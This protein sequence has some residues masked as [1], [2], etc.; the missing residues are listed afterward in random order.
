MNKH[1][2]AAVIGLLLVSMQVFPAQNKAEQ[3]RAEQLAMPLTRQLSAV[4]PDVH[5]K[6]DEGFDDS[7]A[8]QQSPIAIDTT[9]K[10]KFVAVNLRDIIF[11][12]RPL[13]L[14]A[15]NTGHS[16][17]LQPQEVPGSG[18]PSNFIVVDEKPYRFAQ[19][20]FHAPGEHKIDTL[21]Y[22]LEIHLVHTIADEKSP[23]AFNYAVIGIM[24]DIGVE[25]PEFEKILPK[26]PA[27]K[28]LTGNPLDSNF[29]LEKLLPADRRVMRYSGS[30]TTKP[31][32][33]GVTWLL[34]KQPITISKAQYEKIHAIMKHPNAREIQPLKVP[35]VSDLV[36]DK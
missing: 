17:E 6:T 12:Y 24:V 23:G 16:I 20:H 3:K 21:R 14:K 19:L 27:E 29:D 35:V 30:L 4:A 31:F 9:D 26:V 11:H 32:T 33:T 25:N 2:K 13:A 22:P 7:K 36:A 15:L 1:I 28:N 34:I 5:D 8:D 18:V 10:S